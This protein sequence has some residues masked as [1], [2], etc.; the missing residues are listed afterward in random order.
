MTAIA[1]IQQPQVTCRRERRES[2]ERRERPHTHTHI[3]HILKTKKRPA[4]GKGM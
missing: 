1:H 4:A 3:Y 2:R